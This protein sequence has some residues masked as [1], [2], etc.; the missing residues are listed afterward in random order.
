MQIEEVIAIA[1]TL[2]PNFR[3]I[4]VIDPDIYLDNY[5]I[6]Y[7]EYGRTVY[8]GESWHEALLKAGWK[9]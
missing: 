4:S 9:G 6:E 8:Y 2:R 3:Q 5:R 1:K 7:G